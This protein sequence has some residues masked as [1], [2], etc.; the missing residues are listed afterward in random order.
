MRFLAQILVLASAVCFALPS[1][2]QTVLGTNNVIFN[3]GALVPS[4]SQVTSI[5]IRTVE[6]L[7]ANG[8]AYSTQPPA[9]TRYNDAAQI[10][11]DYAI[12][13]NLLCGMACTVKISDNYS[14]ITTNFTITPPLFYDANSNVVGFDYIGPYVRGIGQFYSNPLTKAQ[15]AALG[16][17][18]NTGNGYTLAGTFSGSG[19]GLTNLWDVWN[20]K[21][22]GAIGNTNADDTLA[23]QSALNRGGL[24][25]F[26]PGG[27]VASNLVVTVPVKLDGNGATIIFRPDCTGWLLNGSTATLQ[28]SGLSFNG[29]NV[30]R[31]ITNSVGSRNGVLLTASQLDSSMAG[32]RV[33]GFD[34]TA[35]GVDGPFSPY[36]SRPVS[37]LQS[38]FYSSGIGVKFGVNT[39][40]GEYTRWIGNEMSGNSVGV[41]C[42]VGNVIFSGGIINSNNIAFKLGNRGN[43]GHGVISGCE[44]NHNTTALVATNVTYGE[45]FDS[46][47]M[48]YGDTFVTNCNKIVWRNC[49]LYSTFN[50]SGNTNCLVENNTYL[51]ANTFNQSANDNTI[52]NNNNSTN[53]PV[54]ATP[55]PAVYGQSFG[56]KVED[57]STGA[58]LFSGFVSGGVYEVNG[59][60]AL[61]VGVATTVNNATIS[62]GSGDTYLNLPSSANSF[63]LTIPTVVPLLA[64]NI[65]AATFSSN[66]IAGG[67]F[68]GNGRMITNYA[69]TN[70][71]GFIELAQPI[72]SYWSQAYSPNGGYWPSLPVP[73]NSSLVGIEWPAARLVNES[74]MTGRNT[75]NLSVSIGSTNNATGP[76]YGIFEVTTSVTNFAYSGYFNSTTFKGITNTFQTF[77]V[78]TN[79]LFDARG[80]NLFFYNTTTN[81]YWVGSD[82]G[83]NLQ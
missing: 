47:Q 1:S 18:T 28:V 30:N 69:A 73:D 15:L 56:Q 39:S 72:G 61:P 21:W 76:A 29:T 12:F 79:V 53:G 27:Y 71:A 3:F 64:L 59:I 38:T 22:S 51:T 60:W 36:P 16:V 44:I 10:A 26:P 55:L 20:V 77:S 42:D 65:T 49:N 9:L 19:A 70:L 57:I 8:L 4:P 43:G 52:F 17:V 67:A 24:V 48:L 75:L 23:I 62:T 80:F 63:Y 5:E 14:S 40:G 54:I 74:K 25:I 83:L 7:I 37:V 13:T 31:A 11:N 32:C 58:N 82:A 2:A 34:G 6:P 81:S 45:I 41:D 66:V 35:L 78:P 50:L 68:I 33:F 46:C